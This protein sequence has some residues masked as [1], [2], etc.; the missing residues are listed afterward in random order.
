[1][2]TSV[3]GDLIERQLKGRKKQRSEEAEGQ[4]M[5][6]SRKKEKLRCGL[7]K[8]SGPGLAPGMG[9]KESAPPPPPAQSAKPSDSGQSQNWSRF[10]PVFFEPPAIG[11]ELMVP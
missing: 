8:T 11:A 4:W 6:R 10:L 1:M 7:L 3:H 5:R 2:S 9:I